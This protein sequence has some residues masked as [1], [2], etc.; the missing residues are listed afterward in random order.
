MKGPICLQIQ[1]PE[2]NEI[3][4]CLDEKNFKFLKILNSSIEILL[5]S[6][7][8]LRIKERTQEKRF[9]VRGQMDDDH[10]EQKRKIKYLKNSEFPSSTLVLS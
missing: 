2:K 1:I 6:K 7:L 3:K 8:C 5:F 10:H 4:V 9:D